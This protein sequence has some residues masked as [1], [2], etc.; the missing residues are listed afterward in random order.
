MF[1][2]LIANEKRFDELELK[3]GDSTV[4]NGDPKYSEYLREHGGLLG[5]VTAFKK[6]KKALKELEEAR[7]LSKDESDGEMAEL[8][9]S[10]LPALEE[11]LTLHKEALKDRFISK[12]SDGDRN[13]IMEFRA[14][15][16]GEEASLFASDLVRMYQVFAEK[17]RWKVE[18]MDFSPSD[19]GGFKEFVMAI[20]GRDVYAHLKYESGT[21][22]VQRVPETE[23]QGRTHTSAATVAVLP[24]AEAVDVDIRKDLYCSSG[25]GGQSVNTTYSAVRLTHIPTGVVVCCQDEKS[26]VKNTDKAMRV[27]RSRIYDLMKSESDKKRSDNRRAQIGSGDRSERI[28][29]YNFPQNRLTD[30]RIGLTLYDLSNIIRGEIGQV[31]HALRDEEKKRFFEG[32][33]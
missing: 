21:H 4:I 22:R 17:M 20:S 18:I 30:H 25:P 29:T 9:R 11:A 6:Y 14:G 5:L 19:K 26:Q 33:D 1:E 23:S 32:I 8:A 2:E 15:T 27:L 28:R 12:E 10:E 16:G 13:V 3:I 31:V 24:E 7:L